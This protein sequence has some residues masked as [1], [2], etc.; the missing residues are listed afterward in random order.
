MTCQTA[1]KAVIITNSVP[2]GS[3]P[4][5]SLLTVFNTYVKV[6]FMVYK[7]KTKNKCWYLGRKMAIYTNLLYLFNFISRIVLSVFNTDAG[8]LVAT[9]GVWSPI[10]PCLV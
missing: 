6:Q 8:T 3:E 1:E 5:L 10:I 4:G 2:W 7:T 9:G